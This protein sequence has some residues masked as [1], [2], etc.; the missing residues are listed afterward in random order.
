MPQANLWIDGYEIDFLWAD[1]A[2][3]V[4]VDGRA[5]HGGTRA[6]HEDRRRDRALL[7]AGIQTARVTWADLREPSR[8][9]DELRRIRAARLGRSSAPRR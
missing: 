8:L 9:A 6:F 5:F 3:A 4:E 2:L 1:A 7:A